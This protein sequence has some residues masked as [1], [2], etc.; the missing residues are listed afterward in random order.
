MR[1]C[2]NCLLPEAVAGANIDDSGRCAY[3][4]EYATADH[5]HEE[6]QRKRWEEDLEQALRTCRGKGEYDC[7][8][9]LSGGKDSCYLVYRLK[10]DYGLNVLTFTTDM[11]VPEVAWENIRRTVDALG[12]EHVVYT[13]PRD[14]YR[15]LYRFLLQNQEERGAVRTVCYV[16]AP[17][18]EG[19]S[20]ALAVERKIP[21]VLAGYS[22][23]QPDPDRMTYEFSRQIIMSDWTPREV[24]DSGLFT[25]EELRLFWNPFRYPEGT[26]FPRYLAPYHAWPYNQTETMKK[27]VELGLIASSKN[28]SP[29]HSNCPLNWLLM[30]SDLKNLKY[31]PYLPEFAK[32]I[33]EGKASRAQWRVT[34]PVV[35]TMI[36]TKSFLGRNVK[37]SLDW[38]D[39]TTDDLKI[40]RPKSDAEPSPATGGAAA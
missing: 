3:C 16:C 7:L 26:A 27:V 32:L 12:V 33:R 34:I 38:L 1:K 10:H 9:N 15:K 40:T 20:L 37:S 31:N 29:V 25:E 18:F 22:P 14:F 39:L 2:R 8:I 21:L 6:V 28:A 17:L 35:N 19:Y 30:Y 13:P 36:R 24:R 11:N 4:R 23:G 5:T